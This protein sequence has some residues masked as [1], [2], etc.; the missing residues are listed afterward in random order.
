MSEEGSKY[1]SWQGVWRKV[2]SIGSE[3][4]ADDVR[5]ADEDGVKEWMKFSGQTRETQR[6]AVASLCVSSCYVGC[7]LR[8]TGRW[9]VGR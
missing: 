3:I 4:A 5:D 9:T 7:A 8:E 1:S 2:P 6:D